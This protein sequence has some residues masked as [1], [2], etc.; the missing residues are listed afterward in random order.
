MIMKNHD[1][2]YHN[3]SNN[4][5][6]TNTFDSNNND[7]VEK[8]N[9]NEIPSFLLVLFLSMKTLTNETSPLWWRICIIAKETYME[10]LY[11]APWV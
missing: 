10:I 4:D 7:N 6:N 8:R 2:D 5:D 1:K 9:H 3:D 11:F